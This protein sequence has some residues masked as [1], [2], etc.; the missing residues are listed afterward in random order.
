MDRLFGIGIAVG[1]IISGVAAILITISQQL[2]ITLLILGGIFLFLF[3]YPKS[4]IRKYWWSV[5]GK[6]GVVNIGTMGINTVGVGAE[7]LTIH[8]GLRAASVIRVDKIV[9]KIGRKSL[10]S[11]WESTRVEADE[12]RY[13][14]F[15]RPD[16][17]HVGEYK[18]N[19]IAYTPDGFSKSERFL[20]EVDK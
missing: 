19:L 8:V 3:A 7:Y 16:W 20:I 6:L 2:G 1:F 9:L 18:A 13:I 15:T 17:L 4:P 5:S 11:N 14:N 10:V 12:T